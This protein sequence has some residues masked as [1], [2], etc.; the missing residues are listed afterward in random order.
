M[1]THQAIPLKRL[2]LSVQNVRRPS[3][4]DGFAELMASIAAYGL[5]QNRTGGRHLSMPQKDGGLSLDA[6]KSIG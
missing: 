1:A 6:T 5:R 4:D 2:V 3:K